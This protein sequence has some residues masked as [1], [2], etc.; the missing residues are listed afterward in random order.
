[1]TVKSKKIT[2]YLIILGYIFFYWYKFELNFLNFINL[3]FVIT[4]M[5]ISVIDI[6]T[7]KISILGMICLLT[8]SILRLLITKD[9]KYKIISFFIMFFIFFIISFLTQAIGGGDGKI[10]TIL[11][12]FGGFLFSIRVF[13]LAILFSFPTSIYLSIVKSPNKNIAFAPYITAGLILLQ[14]IN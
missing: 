13:I 10:F 3:F 11:A 8:I 5:I 12:L 7:H 14:F 6:K 1:M 4:M 9:F 2:A